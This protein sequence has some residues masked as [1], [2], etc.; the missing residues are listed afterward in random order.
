MTQ[1]IDLELVSRVR[2]FGTLGQ[3]QLWKSFRDLKGQ[4]PVYS[5]TDRTGIVYQ[6]SDAW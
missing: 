1:I 6:D 4:F 5:D 3:C 2:K